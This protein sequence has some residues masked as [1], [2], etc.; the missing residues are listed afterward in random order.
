[1]TYG[2]TILLALVFLAPLGVFGATTAADET[3]ELSVSPTDN[4]YL[5][6]AE[7]RVTAPLP[8]DLLA[9]AGSLLVHSFVAGD[10]LLIGGT[11]EVTEGTGGDV[12]VAGGRVLIEG[13]VGGDVAILGAAVTMTG[14]GKEIRVAGGTVELRGGA[15]G[16]VTVYGANVYL[17]GEFL[18]DVHIVA[19]DHV[20]LGDNTVIKGALEYNAPQEAGIPSSAVIDGGV[21]YTGSSAF[22][23]TAKEAETFAL[24]GLGVF[25]LVRLLAGAIA[26][27][28]LA[29]LFPSFSHLLT[30]EALMRSWK[31]F[32]LLVLLGFAVL[33]VTPV[34]LILLVA[35]FVGIGIAALVGAAYLLALVL[36]Y[37]LAAIFAGALLMRLLAK[38]WSVSWKAALLGAVA[39]YLLTLVPFVG[40]LVS[41]VLSLA[42]LGAL[43][44]VFYRSAFGRGER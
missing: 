9:A 14:T 13:D 5:A 38:R 6:G 8:A 34:L 22:L 42:A 17:S 21:R 27:G 40:S 32:A 11:V 35:T 20:T 24:A 19:S 7:V 2:R 29:G 15:T 3:V 33:I 25:L 16:P 31:R 12:R 37:L 18:S 28:L 10:A 44:F 23:P 43:S 26:A 41:F 4:A 39:L 36:S 30:K 1:M